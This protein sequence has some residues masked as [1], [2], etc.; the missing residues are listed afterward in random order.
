[1]PGRT[2]R[3]QHAGVIA[4]CLGVLLSSDGK[5]FQRGTLYIIMLYTTCLSE[6]LCH[7]MEAKHQDVIPMT[8]NIYNASCTIDYPNCV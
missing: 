3:F 4:C 7:E 5:T 8:F 2:Q 6:R 1:M